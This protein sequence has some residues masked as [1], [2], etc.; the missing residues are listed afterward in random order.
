MKFEVEPPAPN[1]G[2]AAPAGPSKTIPEPGAIDRFSTAAGA[3]T[4]NV[5]SGLVDLANSKRWPIVDSK[6]F[7]ELG[8]DLSSVAGGLYKN[9]IDEPATRME[10]GDFAGG[11]GE[12]LPN[13]LML[14]RGTR[15][16]AEALPAESIGRVAGTV[17]AGAAKVADIS[18]FGTLGKLYR[19]GRGVVS[20]LHGAPESPPIFPGAPLPENPGTFPGAHLPENPGVFPGAHLPEHPG[21]FPGAPEPATPPR[22]VLQA[23]SLLRGPVPIADPAAA[24]ETIPVTASAAPGHAGQ[25]VESMTAPEAAPL[26]APIQSPLT[27]E[28]QASAAAPTNGKPADP[29]LERLRARADAIEQEKSTPP[30]NQDLTRSLRK[31]VKVVEQAKQSGESPIEALSKQRKPIPRRKSAD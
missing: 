30:P 16:A 18:S 13:A 21:V 26:S 22:E 8:D 19:V 28:P 17:G 20:G 10:Q 2:L 5:G 6:N 7:S 9:V 15:V 24:L 12:F 3:A 23:N 25:L 14:R 4:A 1:A 11:L 31:S 29:W 27:A